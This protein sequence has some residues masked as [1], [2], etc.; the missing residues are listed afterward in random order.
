M[1]AT[2]RDDIVRSI[3][4]LRAF[5]MG[6]TRS[7]DR[8]D[9]L[10]QD[11]MLRAFARIDTFESGTNLQAWLFTILR[12]SFYSSLRKRQ[13]EV[14]DAD[15]AYAARLMTPPEQEGRLLYNDFLRAFGKLNPDQRE[16]LLL[17][18]ASGFPFEDAAR[19]MGVALGTAKSRVIRARARLAQLMEIDADKDLG[20]DQ[21]T[22]AAM[23]DS[24]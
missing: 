22:Q 21:Q 24:P 9:D 5:A 17:V 2:L 3:P 10:V 15:G 18:A 6:L 14:D 7:M 20:P 12:N 11:T 8:A 1:D 4:S 13:R 19:I 23:H 16:A